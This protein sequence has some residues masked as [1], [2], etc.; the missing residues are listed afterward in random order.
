MTKS[1]LVE[2]MMKK[3]RHLSKMEVEVIVDTVFNKIRETLKKKN[4]VELRGFG[5][6]EVRFREARSGRNPKSGQKVSVRD[7]HVPFFRV[8]KELKD[9]INQSG[10][11]VG[12]P[13]SKAAK[14]HVETQPNAVAGALL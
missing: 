6:F 5:I 1:D 3:L 4:R 8:G 2:I 14:Q 11:A 10:V 12:R 9:K 7:R 13:V